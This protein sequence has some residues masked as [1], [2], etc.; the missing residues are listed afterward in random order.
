[1]TADADYGEG[2]G[3]QRRMEVGVLVAL[4]GGGFELRAAHALS[5]VATAVAQA[6]VCESAAQASQALVPRLQDTLAMREDALC[7]IR[8]EAMARL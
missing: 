7:G 5:L 8:A 1:M 6:L 2:S 3:D 4:K